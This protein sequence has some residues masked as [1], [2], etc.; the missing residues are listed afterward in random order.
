MNFFNFGRPA[1]CLA[2]SVLY[3]QLLFSTISYIPF[4]CRC[5]PGAI[6]RVAHSSL[7]LPVLWSLP[8][9]CDR[10]EAI[11]FYRIVTVTV[12]NNIQWEVIAYFWRT[13]LYY[14]SN[15]YFKQ[16]MR[17]ILQMSII[18]YWGADYSKSISSHVGN[19]FI[20]LTVERIIYVR[21]IWTKYA[22]YSVDNHL[23]LHKVFI[24]YA[25]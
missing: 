24:S 16:K 9:G 12:A 15:Y 14:C 10:T 1:L 22:W 21:T 5:R 19:E 4:C 23:L 20:C 11:T 25:F 8:H 6:S 13:R 3:E 17:N 7:S 18:Q 2:F